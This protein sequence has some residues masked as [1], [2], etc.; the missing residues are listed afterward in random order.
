MNKIFIIICCSSFLLT[1]GFAQQSKGNATAYSLVALL[2]NG[3][4]IYL[5][6]VLKEVQDIFNQTEDFYLVDIEGTARNESLKKA[7]EN[8]KSD[9]W[10]DDKKI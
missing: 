7:K 1:N 9:N 10:I 2:Q 6:N 5:P 3:A 4:T 8:Y